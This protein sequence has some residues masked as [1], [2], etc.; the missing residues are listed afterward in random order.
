[1]IRFSVRPIRDRRHIDLNG[2]FLL[3]VT[4]ED[5]KA[6]GYKT[7]EALYKVWLAAIQKAVADAT[8]RPAPR[9]EQA[10]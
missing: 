4:P 10:P 1:V 9:E 2:E 3:A 5:A 7:A 6:T 8:A